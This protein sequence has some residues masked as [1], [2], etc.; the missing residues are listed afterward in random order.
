MQSHQFFFFFKVK[1]QLDDELL[2]LL[3]GKRK[4]ENPSEEK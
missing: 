2:N 3:L 1:N 4:G